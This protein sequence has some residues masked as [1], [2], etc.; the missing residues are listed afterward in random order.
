[1]AK[2]S[3]SKARPELEPL[4]SRE[5][6]TALAG[7]DPL[8]A[9][10]SV[11]VAAAPTARPRPVAFRGLGQVT[12]SAP[13]VLSNGGLGLSGNG[14][15]EALGIGNFTGQ[16]TATISPDLRGF[17]ATATFQNTSGDSVQATFSGHYRKRIN[18]S[19]GTGLFIVTG[20]TGHF[21]NA[22]GRGA[23]LISPILPNG[24]QASQATISFH[25]LVRP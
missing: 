2:R 12:F 20:G 21:A 8:T 14:S 25:G 3:S 16:V 24:S 13:A 22:T 18:T 15:G 10:A 5:T 4:E 1:M 19:T 23:V 9:L 6:P 7:A 17:T 11:H